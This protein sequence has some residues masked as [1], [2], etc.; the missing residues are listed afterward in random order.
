M[1]G[2]SHLEE[3]VKKIYT[4]KKNMLTPESIDMERIAAALKIWLHFE[5]KKV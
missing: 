5:K 1:K 3:E 2:L 4:K